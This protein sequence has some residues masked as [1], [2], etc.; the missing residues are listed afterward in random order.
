MPVVLAV[1]LIGCWTLEGGIQSRV[2]ADAREILGYRLTLAHVRSVAAAIHA[3]DQVPDRGPEAPRDDVAVFAVLA[4]SLPYNRP[5]T[6]ESVTDVVRSIVSGMPDLAKA[7]AK[8]DISPRDYVLAQITLLL[9]YPI[10][11]QQRAGRRTAVPVDVSSENVAFVTKHWVEVD[12]LIA[13]L[14]SRVA[15]AR[16]GQP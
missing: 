2:A 4:M 16:R 10:A 5:Y 7:I 12:R 9:T 3:M 14:N 6:D 11:T 13:D 8:A 1:L 15:A